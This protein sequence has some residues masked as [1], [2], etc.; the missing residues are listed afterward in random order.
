MLQS[1]SPTAMPRADHMSRSTAYREV[2]AP[3]EPHMYCMSNWHEQPNSTIHSTFIRSLQTKR[4]NYRTTHSF[5][6]ETCKLQA[7]LPFS[8]VRC[9]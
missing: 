3:S 2:S 4:G 7:I 1:D 8:L 9:S 5:Q 6:C